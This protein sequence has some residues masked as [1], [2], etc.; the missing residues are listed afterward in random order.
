M[1]STNQPDNDTNKNFSMN[2]IDRYKIIEILHPKHEDM[3]DEHEDLTININNMINENNIMTP[4]IRIKNK[5][6]PN[7]KKIFNEVKRKI[8]I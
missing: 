6:P 4:N 7:Q 5:Y 8:N 1:E 2:S 3:I